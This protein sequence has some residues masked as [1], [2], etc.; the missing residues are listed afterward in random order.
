MKDLKYLFAYIAPLAAFLGIYYGGIWSPGALYVAFGLIPLLELFSNGSTQNLNAE[1][2]EN[3]LS[4][5]LFD[6]LLYLNIPILF[7]LLGYYFS[8]IATG[9][10]TTFEVVGITC[11]VGVMV[12]TIGINV[13]HELGHRNTASEQFMSKLL[14]MSALY[15]HFFIEHN[16]GH[17]KNVATDKDPAS[18]RFGEN[19][20]GF[21][22]RSTWGSYQHAWALEHN[23]L[24]K[25]GQSI[26]SWH[27]EM[28]RFQIIQILYLLSIGAFFGWMVVPFA[29]YVAIFGFLLLET[30]NYVEHYGLRR[31]KL[32]SGHYEKVS[33]HHS[34]NSNHELGRIFLYE[35]TRHSDHHFKANRKYQILRHMDSSPQLPHGYPVSMILSMVPPLWFAL[36][37]KEVKRYQQQLSLST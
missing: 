26:F 28:L 12:G 18:A 14:L 8:T 37:N 33:P 10:L 36:M 3:R 16:R 29:I 7:V 34:W 24:A 17:H 27:N 25:K 11:N 4:N 1:E 6:W 31:Q 19:L 5:R 20:Y 13:A 30:V 15:M 22:L 23:R 9:G 32:A 35:L 2:A 21:W